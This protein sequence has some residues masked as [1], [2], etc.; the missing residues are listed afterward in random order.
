MGN[1]SA[2]SIKYVVTVGSESRSNQ[3]VKT[4][5]QK[6]KENVLEKVRGEGTVP[7]TDSQKNQLIYSF[8]LIVI[9][10]DNHRHEDPN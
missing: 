2:I 9:D 5:N 1:V 4:P 3:T 10:R 7:L 8:G 6:R